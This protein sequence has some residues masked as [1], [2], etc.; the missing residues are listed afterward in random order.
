MASL[1]K[2]I[3]EI[4]RCGALFRALKFECEG[5]SGIQT[6][7][8]L[9]ICHNDGCTQEK[10][11]RSLYIHKSTVTRQLVALE[12][13]G[14]IVRTVDSEDKRNMLVFSTQKTKEMLPKLED[15]FIEWRQYLTEDLTEVEKKS[16][17][18]ILSKLADRAKKYIMQ[19]EED[20]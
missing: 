2:M 20:F 16:M 5:L 17:E 10:I 14:F 6:S 8:I 3:N 1:M 18:N 15:A 13:K 9:Y 4:Y 7:F 19:T 12:E 11:A